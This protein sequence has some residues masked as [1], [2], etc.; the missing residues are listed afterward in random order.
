MIPSACVVTS[1][2]LA[3]LTNAFVTMDA[4]EKRAE[5]TYKTVGWGVR[6]PAADAGT[7]GRAAAGMLSVQACSA[8]TRV[9]HLF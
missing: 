5:L 6:K 7:A 8:A 9:P 2:S 3:D 1:P 4:A